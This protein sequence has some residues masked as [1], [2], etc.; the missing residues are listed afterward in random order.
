MASLKDEMNKVSKNDKKAA[1]KEKIFSKRKADKQ[2]KKDKFAKEVREALAKI[3]KVYPKVKGT[4]FKEDDVR[5]I[6]DNEG[7]IAGIVGD[8][9]FA[10]RE[11]GNIVFYS[12]P[13]LNEYS[14]E[15]SFGNYYSCWYSSY[16]IDVKL[17]YFK[18]FIIDSADVEE[19]EEFVCSRPIKPGD[20][21]NPPTDSDVKAAYYRLGYALIENEIDRKIS[22][23]SDKKDVKK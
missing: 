4:I 12:K 9:A 1:L 3:M 17:G 8:F 15:T 20:I 10:S 7:N 13:N 19:K 21:I 23:V 11:N 18:T 16:A 22:S 5:M 6:K 14:G 2:E